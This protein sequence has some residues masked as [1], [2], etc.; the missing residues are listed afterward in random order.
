L[1][2]GDFRGG[3]IWTKL[4]IDEDSAVVDAIFRIR[5]AF[6]T[7]FAPLVDIV[8]TAFTNVKLIIEAFSALFHGDFYTFGEKLREIWDNTW[9]FLT[10]RVSEAWENIKSAAVTIVEGIK[11]VFAIDWSELGANIINGIINGLRNGISAVIQM[12]RNV[13]QAAAQ[14]IQG[15][16]GIQSPSKLMYQYGQMTAQGF[17]NGMQAGG[18]MNIP[19]ALGMNAGRIAAPVSG[20]GGNNITINIENPK[21]ETAEESIRRALKSLSYT[22]VIPA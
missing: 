15:F 18:T 11:A 20:G 19:A 17:A 3:G 14:A 5:D 13:A 2:T 21:K 12:A 9:G 6:T 8:K 7:A 10:R 16:L 4:G 1:F 22:G